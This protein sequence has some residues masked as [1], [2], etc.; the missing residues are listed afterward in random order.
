MA[1]FQGLE[2]TGNT[3][4]SIPGGT[5]ELAISHGHW[6]EGETHNNPIRLERGRIPTT[7]DDDYPIIYRVLTIPGGAGFRPSTVWLLNHV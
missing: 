3:D 2:E 5:L 6:R 4:W 7:K 1:T